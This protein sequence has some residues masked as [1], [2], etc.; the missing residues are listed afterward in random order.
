MEQLGVTIVSMLNNVL[1]LISFDS[2]YNLR[3]IRN[4]NWFSSGDSYRSFTEKR[5]EMSKLKFTNQPTFLFY[6]KFWCIYW[7]DYFIVNFW[8]SFLNH[9]I[10]LASL[11]LPN[12]L[13]VLLLLLW[14]NNGDINR[15]D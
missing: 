12:K 7:V 3:F 11:M 2:T 9:L 1:N 14:S 6:E 5:V 8:N 4:F 15:W 10:Q 13:Q